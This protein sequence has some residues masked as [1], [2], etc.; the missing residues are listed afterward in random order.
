MKGVGVRVLA[1]ED[2]LSFHLNEVDPYGGGGPRRALRY[3]DALPLYPNREQRLVK[4]YTCVHE[5]KN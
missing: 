5:R 2:T 4:H 1:C 3:Q